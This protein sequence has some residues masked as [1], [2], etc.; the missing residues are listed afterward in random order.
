MPRKWKPL[1]KG[2]GGSCSAAVPAA[3][4]DGVPPPDLS[5]GG[6]GDSD[7]CTGTVPELAAGDGRAASLV[8]VSA[9][10]GIRRPDCA[11]DEPPVQADSEV[12]F[13]AQELGDL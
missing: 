11:G 10:F 13:L 12:P 6:W 2:S 7:S 9:S 1:T 3:S 5:V 8:Q 4:S